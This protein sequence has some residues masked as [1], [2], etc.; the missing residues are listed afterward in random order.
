[1][2]REGLGR[3]LAPGER[4]QSTL[5]HSVSWVRRLKIFPALDREGFNWLSVTSEAGRVGS[6]R[7]GEPSRSLDSFHGCNIPDYL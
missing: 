5:I 1:M 4:E 3:V 6:R 7:V 2:L